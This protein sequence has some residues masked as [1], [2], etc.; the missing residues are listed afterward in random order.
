M[1][2]RSKEDLLKERKDKN[3]MYHKDLKAKKIKE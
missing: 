2:L 3:P 1:N